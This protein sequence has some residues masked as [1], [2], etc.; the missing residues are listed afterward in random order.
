MSKLIRH[1]KKRGAALFVV[2]QLTA[3][4][5]LSLVSFIGGPQSRDGGTPAETQVSAP[6]AGGADA[7]ISSDQA[8]TETAQPLT[9][10]DK[11]ALRKS[12]HF[13]KKLY[14]PHASQVF[15]LAT[16]RAAEAESQKAQQTEGPESHNKKK[17]ATLTTDREDYAQY[18]YVYFTGSGFQ[19]G[20]TVNMIVVETNPNQ[21]SFQPWDVVA[22]ENG[23]FDTSWY[24]FSQDFNGATFQATATGDSSQLS[25][26]VTPQAAP[27]TGSISIKGGAELNSGSVNTAT[28]VTGWLDGIGAPPAVVSRSGDFA[29]YV[30]VGASVTMAAPWNFGFGLPNLWSVGGFTFNLTASSIVTQANGFLNVSGTGTITRTGFTPTPGTWRFSTQNPPASGVFSFSASTTAN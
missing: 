4:T 18:T 22:D 9:A 24:V 23:E 10:A 17:K 28:Q 3:L 15:N 25:A 16:S 5:F 21:Q 11:E 30:S 2:L 19:P 27:I 29:T 7:G 13:A 1:T 26:G 20:E 12:A 8:Q 6:V 14:E